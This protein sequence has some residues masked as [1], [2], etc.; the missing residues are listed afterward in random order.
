MVTLTLDP[1]VKNRPRFGTEIPPLEN[2]DR[3]SAAEFLRRYDAMPQVNK[4]ELVQGI[5]YMPSPVRIDQHGEPDNFV[6]GLLFNYAAATPGVR[7]ATNSTTRL[8]RDDVPQPD[9]LLRILPEHGGQSRVGAKGLLEGAPELAF[10]V[11]ASSASIDANDK[12]TTYRRAGVLEYVVWRTLDGV[13]DWW[14]L[15][16]D[17]YQPLEPDEAGIYRSRVFP[18]LWID[19][20]ALLAQ[21]APRLLETLNRGLADQT[22]AAFVAALKAIR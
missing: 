15:E 17:E 5:V 12:K 18:G 7:A 4:A 3:L 19:A 6:Q 21:D 22:H 20:G 14:Q 13:I 16:D 9:G 11:A 8:G 1:P 2:G 10:E